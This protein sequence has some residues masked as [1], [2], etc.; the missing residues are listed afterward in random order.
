AAAVVRFPEAARLSGTVTD[1]DGRPLAGAPVTLQIAGFS[2]FADR[3]RT[4]SGRDGGWSASLSSQYT[5]TL[6][7]VAQLP[8][9]FH[10]ATPPLPAKVAPRIDV[11]APARVLAKRVLTVSGSV[12]PAQ[13]SRLVLEIARRGSDALFHTVARV[14]VRAFGGR[15]RR[16]VRLRRPALHRLR[17]VSGADARN[18]AGR[19]ADVYVRALRAGG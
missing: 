6:R 16:V 2:G 8:G 9:G 12:A 17:V 4:V 7:A 14:P 13:R 18:V 19:S 11:R 5:R 15:F 1:A 10:V 3:L